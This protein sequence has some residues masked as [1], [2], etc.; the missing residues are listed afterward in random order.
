MLSTIEV[1]VGAVPSTVTVSSS[2]T[3]TPR[4]LPAR[5]LITAPDGICRIRVPAVLA[6]TGT[7]KTPAEV[8]VMLP[9]LIVDVPEFT[10]SVAST[11]ASS[12][13]SLNVT[14]YVR[15]DPG[16]TRLSASP[17][18]MDCTVGAVTSVAL[19]VIVVS[20]CTGTTRSFPARSSTTA[21]DANRRI[22]VP[23][24]A[25]VT[26]MENTPAAVSVI[27]PTEMVDVPA[28]SRSAAVSEPSR[29]SSLK[30]TV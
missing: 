25:G 16:A 10:K 12:M 1:N 27:V 20:S 5:S 28:L 29:I 13:S 8:S 7:L 6:V 30:V 23:A 22:S 19:T 2:V 14:V 18:S 17:S 24:V 21:S 4:S 9:M 26:S 11:V 15:T 3:G